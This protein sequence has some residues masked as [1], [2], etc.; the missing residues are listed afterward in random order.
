ML[1]NIKESEERGITMVQLKYIKKKKYV[2]DAFRGKTKKKKR[3]RKSKI[4]KEKL[5]ERFV[6]HLSIIYSI[7]HMY[8]Y[9][10][11]IPFPIKF[12]SNDEIVVL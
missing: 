7:S 3:K 5:T 12:R 11:A 4:I 6:R 1:V 8:Q 9:I 10:I 2:C